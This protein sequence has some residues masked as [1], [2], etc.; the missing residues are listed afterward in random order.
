MRRLLADI[1][2]GDTDK[3]NV[4]SDNY[5]MLG[6]PLSTEKLATDAV[7]YHETTDVVNFLNIFGNYYFTH[8]IK[9]YISN[10]IAFLFFNFLI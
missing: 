8:V 5:A 7:L 6:E 10:I 3:P 1:I 2:P 9:K 4:C